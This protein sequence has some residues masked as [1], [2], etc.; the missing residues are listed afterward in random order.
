MFISIY[1][2]TSKMNIPRKKKKKSR[3]TFVDSSDLSDYSVWDIISQT[4][5]ICSSD[6]ELHIFF[7]AASEK[8]FDF[9][10]V[11]VIVLQR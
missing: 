2:D 10:L 8:A 6:K 3:K 11:F 7:I 9:F 4:A 5:R 1:R